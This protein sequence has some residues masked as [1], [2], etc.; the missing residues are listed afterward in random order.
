MIARALEEFIPL[1]PEIIEK[2][3]LPAEKIES[4]KFLHING[5]N[6]LGGEGNSNLPS[7][8]NTGGSIIQTLMSVSMLLPLMKEIVKTLKT[9]NDFGDILQSIGQMPGG[10]SLLQYIENFQEKNKNKKN[11]DEAQVLD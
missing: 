8:V 3:M 5:M 1:L 11:P 7:A 10:E 2:L 9:D 6:G 4:I